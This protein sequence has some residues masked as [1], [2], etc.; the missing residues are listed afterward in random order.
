MT[1]LV[2]LTF[3]PALAAIMFWLRARREQRA[4]LAADSRIAQL[5]TMLASGGTKSA[6]GGPLAAA[7]TEDPGSTANGANQTPAGIPDA[8]STL[9]GLVAHELRSPLAA[10]LGYQELLAEG[11]FGTLDQRAEEAAT[12][13][14][15]AAHQ[16]LHLT[17]GMSEL[18][19]GSPESGQ[20][21]TTS[22]PLDGAISEAVDRAATEG[23][24]RGVNLTIAAADPLPAIRTDPIRLQRIIDLMLAAAI[25]AT[26]NGAL[27]ISAEHDAR[28]VRIIIA[29]SRL[30][31]VRDL[32]GSTAD[33]LKSG[34]GLRLAMAHAA[35]HA[36]GGTIALE[37]NPADNSVVRLELRLPRG[38]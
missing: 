38:P 26:P 29:G 5:E 27:T 14:R 33:A 31:P 20:L 23:A 34:A 22:V 4:R 12:R 6:G 30:D 19:R 13:I 16:L 9:L 18:A 15:Y 1:G 35:A 11:I 28:A 24:G 37:P 17:D 7:S 25:K 3:I 2:V 8:T 21:D 36:V 32:P 10:I